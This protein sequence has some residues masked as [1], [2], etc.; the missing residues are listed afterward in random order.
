MIT[1]CFISLSIAL[2][3]CTNKKPINE[4]IEF[5]EVKE[6]YILEWGEKPED[7][8]FFSK[9]Q[10]AED[11]KAVYQYDEH[12]LN[13]EQKMNIDVYVKDAIE[14]SK[15]FEVIIKDTK[16]PIIEYDGDTVLAKDSEFNLKKHLSVYDPMGEFKMD[17]KY[18]Y[19][20]KDNSFNYMVHQGDALLQDVDTS[21]SG[22]QEVSIYAKDRHGNM[23]TKKIV[24]VVE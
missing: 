8:I 4:I 7:E 19:D 5:K 18:Q 21:I 9:K 10:N 12:K 1:V 24:L 11:I 22:E 2:S 23:S 3:A 20:L 14:D 16:A 6:P 13:D 15:S 17:L